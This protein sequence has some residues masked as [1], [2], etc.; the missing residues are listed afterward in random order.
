[1]KYCVVTDAQQHHYI[2]RSSMQISSF[3]SKYYGNESVVMGASTRDYCSFLVTDIHE[4]N[5]CKVVILFLKL[6]QA[7]A[8]MTEHINLG[9]TLLTRYGEGA[10]K[11]ALNTI[12]LIF[13][14]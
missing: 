5:D 11:S 8:V 3:N 10:Q 9:S 14:A 1:M 4:E 13:P 6:R 7:A 2:K 12:C